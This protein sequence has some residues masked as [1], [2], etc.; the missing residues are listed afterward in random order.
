M[1]NFS[2]WKMIILRKIEKSQLLKCQNDLFWDSRFAKIDFTKNLSGSQ[3]L[4]FSHCV[5]DEVNRFNPWANLKRFHE[6][7]KPEIG[8]FLTTSPK[9][10][11]L[12][13]IS[14]DLKRVK[15]HSVEISWFSYHLDFTWNQF[16]RI[17]KF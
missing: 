8:A 11:F 9:S 15:K 17:L 13:L 4:E 14:V 2:L 6:V 1:K 5:T 12:G 16:C 10:W 7:V 3:F